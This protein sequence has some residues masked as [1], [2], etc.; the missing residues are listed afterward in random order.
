M[1]PELETDSIAEL[2]GGVAHVQVSGAGATNPEP[3]IAG[4]GRR[5]PKIL[6][7]DLRAILADGAA[8]N[9]MIGI[10]ETYLPAF[11]LALGL[12][13]VTAGLMATAPM[14][15][16]AFLQLITPWGIR[17]VRSHRA[18]VVACATLQATSFLP[19]IVAAVA[20][21]MPAALLFLIAAIYW[22]AGLSSSA[23]WNTWV[24]TLVP[25]G[26]RA[27]YYA[28]RTRFGQVG[29][30]LGFVGGGLALQYGAAQGHALWAFACL[31][32]V[33]SACRY[34]SA[35]FMFSQSEPSPPD[36]D[37]RR[38]PFSQLVSG[39]K[40][41]GDGALLTYF[42]AMQ[43]A[44]QISGPYFTPFMLRQIEFSYFEY[45]I[46]IGTSFLAKV[47]ALP[48]WGRIAH[49]H[50]AKTL[51]VIGGI[52]IVPVAG[53]WVFSRSYPF[54]IAVQVLGGV[55]WAA[56]ELAMFLLFFETIDEE[57][58]TS[59]LTWYNLANAMA[60]AGGSLTGALFLKAFGERIDAYLWLFG[61]S[62]F[63]RAATVGLLARVRVGRRTPAVE[64][65]DADPP[66]ARLAAIEAR[67]IPE[68]FAV[69][70][71]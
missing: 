46:L 57:E 1:A 3:L 10:G 22:G 58:R 23:A 51:L 68:D 42:L 45:A 55:T 12:G 41:G 35:G 24:G 36:A 29:T 8:C 44:V 63:G 32:S 31:F 53:F 66:L 21:R 14:L 56:Y 52:G 4:D 18:W 25:S 34:A 7:K 48:T 19:M 67:R 39:W 9:V 59:V 49:R 2:P 47:V 17:R 33:A 50:G 27:G 54:L 38:V 13:D 28:R 43:F 69:I 61:I 71:E 11:A 40:A 65:Q 37:H 70:R 15:L 20:G 16:G 64:P 6:R 5:D 26:M 30:M 60:T 62:T